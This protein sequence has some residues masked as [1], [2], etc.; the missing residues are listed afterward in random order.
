MSLMSN[1]TFAAT[2]FDG[3]DVFL[4]LFNQ[5]FHRGL[6]RKKQLVSWLGFAFYDGH[7]DFLFLASESGASVIP[8][9]IRAR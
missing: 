4:Q 1:G 8:Q 2:E 9:T 3:G 6:V 5:H 7:D